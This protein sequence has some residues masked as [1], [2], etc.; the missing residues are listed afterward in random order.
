ME[1]MAGFEISQHIARD[2]NV[3]SEKRERDLVGDAAERC[4][5]VLAEEDRNR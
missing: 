1:R 4:P 2:G 3:D 5:L